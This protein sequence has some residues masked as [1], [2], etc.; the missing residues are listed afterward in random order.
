MFLL[1]TDHISLLQQPSGTEFA[2]LSTRMRRYSAN[3]FFFSVVS[4]HEQ[5]LGWNAFINNARDAAKILRGYRGFESL[6]RQYSKPQ[7]LPYDQAALTVF[8][9]LRSQRVRIGAFDLR[10][11]AVAL[12]RDLTLLSRNLVDFRQVPGLHVEDWIQ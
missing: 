12:C 3:E 7:I 2:R 10:I 5:S 6:I 9:S 11:A 4:F 8:E 1:D